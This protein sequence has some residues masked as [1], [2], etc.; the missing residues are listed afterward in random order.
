[1]GDNF[2]CGSNR[3]FIADVLNT[4]NRRECQNTWYWCSSR[5]SCF[6]ASD[7]KFKLALPA[8]RTAALLSAAHQIVPLPKTCA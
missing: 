2:F 7:R 4:P 8:G 1:M 6:R 5:P 3:G